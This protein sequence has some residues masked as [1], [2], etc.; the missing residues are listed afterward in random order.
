MKTAKYISALYIL[1]AALAAHAGTT[2]NYTYDTQHRL[3]SVD[4]SEVQSPAVVT[5]QYDAAGNIDVV[6]TITENQYLNSFIIWL[7]QYV[8]NNNESVWV[9]FMSA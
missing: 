2:I 9:R 1:V 5:Y 7:S 3:T 8:P 6:S 4:Y